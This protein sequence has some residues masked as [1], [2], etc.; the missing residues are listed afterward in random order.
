[1]VHNESVNVWSHCFG[2]LFFVI[3]GLILTLAVLYNR[4]SEYL[5]VYT[6]LAPVFSMPLEETKPEKV[7]EVWPLYVHMTVAIIQMGA[8]AY[9]HLFMC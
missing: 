8:S 6:F 2:V 4:T 3:F 7:L 5:H 9:Y 1:M